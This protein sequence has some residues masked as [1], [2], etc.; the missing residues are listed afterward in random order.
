MKRRN[1][2]RGRGAFQRVYDSGRRVNGSLVS[3]VLL[4]EPA[5]EHDLRVG[6]AVSSRSY[7]AVRRNRIRRLLRQAMRSEGS[8]LEQAIRRSAP[9]M[10]AVIVAFRPRG[11]VDVRRLKL[12]TVREDLGAVVRR[13][14]G[15]L[16]H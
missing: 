6:F 16:D 9:T 5:A 13:L 4:A 11:A 8:V 15:H 10:V 1:V 2:L 12:E 3:C 7:G 14:A